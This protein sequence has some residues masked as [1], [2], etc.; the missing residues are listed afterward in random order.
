M[1]HDTIPTKVMP[2]PDGFAFA[3]VR[4][5]DLALV[6][7][8][9]QI[10]RRDR[11]LVL[12]P[13]AMVVHMSDDDS[14]GGEEGQPVAWVFEGLDASL[15]SLH[16]EEGFRGR[17]LARAVVRELFRRTATGRKGVGEEWVGHSDV[18]AD[19]LGSM[20]VAKALGGVLG[21][22]VYWVY[23]DLTKVGSL[24]PAG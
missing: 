10:P 12:L 11:T 20:A 21:W 2:L 4:P 19:N 23:I 14:E 9:T 17:G 7:S 16:C 22:D 18:M 24:H 8:R 3:S 5:Q 6:R 13:S 1:H 15:T